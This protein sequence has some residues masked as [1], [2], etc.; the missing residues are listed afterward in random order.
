MIRASLPSKVTLSFGLALLLL[1][2]LSLVT[3]RDALVLID[4]NR[5]VVHTQEVLVTLEQVLSDLKDT[6]TGQ[7]GY[8][9]T[10][11]EPY[12]EPYN[13]ARSAVERR[14]Q[15]LYTLTA[16]NPDQQQRLAVLEPLVMQKLAELQETIALRARAGFD[17]AVQVVRTDRGKQLMDN[18]RTAV[19]DMVTAEQQLLS[20][21][22]HTAEAEAHITRSVII[23]SDGLAVLL[24]TLAGYTILSDLTKRRQAEREL[25]TLN[26]ELEHRV[27]ERTQALQRSEAAER[28]QREYFQVTLTSI[29]DAVIVTNPQGEVTFLN[30]VAEAVTGW[31]TA[32]ARD[33]PLPEIFHIVN[34]E[35]RLPVENPVDKVLRTGGIAGLANHTILIKKDGSVCPIDDSA[36]PIRNEHG[37]LLGIVLVF[38]DIME[39]KRAEDAQAQLV[40]KLQ[41]AHD[42]LQQFAY[43]VSHDLSEPLRTMRNFVQ[44]LA[45]RTEGKL[46]EEV[47]DYM[48]FVVEAAQR[49]QQML[50]D[51]LAYTRVGDTREFQPVDCEAV[52]T[53]VLS[54]L[55]TRITECDAFI[56]HDPLPTIKGDAT[57][58]GQV[59]QNLIENALKF[60]DKQPPQEE[61]HIKR[62][63]EDSIR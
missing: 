36:A 33:K 22:T 16:D 5:G 32:E 55:Q 20:Q 30:R 51:L 18:I 43:I 31:G 58:V 42:E 29:G 25:A 39:R 61:T 23:Y 2:F 19:Q 48:A 26:A 59:I 56:T 54:A 12:L 50:T 11:E 15:H 53:R 21:R 41:H 40:A 10:G 6:E 3:Y 45:R 46:D 27:E 47:H 24:V 52:L 38:R 34:E 44:L 8:L 63:S 49:M 28:A 37:R 7:R 35:T 14:M 62:E 60:C 4:S 57:R 13:A 17:A 1:L 9:I